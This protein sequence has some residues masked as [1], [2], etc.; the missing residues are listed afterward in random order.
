MA[1]GFS[2]LLSVSMQALSHSIRAPGNPVYGC[3]DIRVDRPYVS[4]LSKALPAYSV[5]DSEH[6]VEQL[7]ARKGA[8]GSECDGDP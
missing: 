8:V 1:I 6:I 3:L 4:I 5:A 7:H 2:P